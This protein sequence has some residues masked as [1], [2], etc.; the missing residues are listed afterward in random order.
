MGEFRVNGRRGMVP[1]HEMGHDDVGIFDGG[2]D[3]SE[4]WIVMRRN[5]G[6]ICIDPNGRIGIWASEMSKS[7]TDPVRI[8]PKGT[9]IAVEFEV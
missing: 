1:M 7:L 5:G 8:L 3:E 9:K 6:V 2:T 4:E